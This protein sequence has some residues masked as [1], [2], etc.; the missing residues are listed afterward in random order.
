MHLTVPNSD[1]C[2]NGHKVGYKPGNG[3]PWQCR[4]P[5]CMYYNGNPFVGI[6]SITFHNKIKDL[7]N[8][9]NSRPFIPSEWSKEVTE[10]KEKLKDPKYRAYVYYLGRYA[11]GKSVPEFMIGM[12]LTEIEGMRLGE[13]EGM[14]LPKII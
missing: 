10:H 11:T 12:K 3:E 7:S 8:T 9:L 5:G 2:L 13:I 4:Q 6:D 14:T 1:M